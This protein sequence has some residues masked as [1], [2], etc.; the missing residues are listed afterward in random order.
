[1][2]MFQFQW[3]QYEMGKRSYEDWVGMNKD[4]HS[5]DISLCLPT[6]TEVT[7]EERQDIRYNDRHSKLILS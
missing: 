6:K 1:M 7:H 5:V 2:M 3:Q 4:D